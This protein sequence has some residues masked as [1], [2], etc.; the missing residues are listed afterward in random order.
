MRARENEAGAGWRSASL[1]AKFGRKSVY[2]RFVYP[3]M[4]AT[5]MAIPAQKVAQRPTEIASPETAPQLMLLP[6]TAFGTG[7]STVTPQGS[8]Q[9]PIIA[10]DLI[11]IAELALRV[12]AWG[13]SCK[14]L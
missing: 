1:V 7:S 5:M 3:Q 4:R 9:G 11:A 14:T 8:S 13:D 10:T 2:S 12:L 6:S